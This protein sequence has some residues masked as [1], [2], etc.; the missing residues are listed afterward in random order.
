MKIPAFEAGWSSV[1]FYTSTT[2]GSTDTDS[3]PELIYEP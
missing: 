2:E 1:T 3:I